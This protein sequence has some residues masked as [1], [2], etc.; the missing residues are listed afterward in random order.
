M[1]KEAALG[2]SNFH[3][4]KKIWKSIIVWDRV[5]LSSTQTPSVQ[6]LGSTQRPHQKRLNSTPKTP[7][8]NKQTPSVQQQKLISSNPFSSTPKTLQFYTVFVWGVC[9]S[10][11]FLMW[12]WGACWTEGSLVWNWGISGAEKEWPFCVELMC[13]TEGG[14]ELRGSN[15]SDFFPNS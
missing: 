5:P 4:N 9:W 2:H 15:S 8:F 11:G 13:W 3:R 12:N 1:L 10:E 14:V 7:Q 6:Q